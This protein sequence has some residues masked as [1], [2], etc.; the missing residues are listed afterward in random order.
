M[1]RI[2]VN[3]RQG[4][5]PV[6]S[7]R[8]RLNV[9]GGAR[10]G[11][12]PAGEGE[13]QS[14]RRVADQQVRSRGHAERGGQ[15]SHQGKHKQGASGAQPRNKEEGSEYQMKRKQAE[16]KCQ[17]YADEVQRLQKQR[18]ECKRKCKGAWSDTTHGSHGM[19]MLI[20]FA[21][22]LMRPSNTSRDGSCS[23]TCVSWSLNFESGL[24]ASYSIIGGKSC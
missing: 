5:V 1:L 16:G 10:A 20:I 23:R 3:W 2:F 24:A 21:R 13:M 12:V 6:A 9:D 14:R 19:K 4:G 7:E 15:Q 11:E 22:W 8:D 18:C 17:Q